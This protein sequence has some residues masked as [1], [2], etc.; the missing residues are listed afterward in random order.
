[1][2]AA[3]LLPL[4][5]QLTEGGTLAHTLRRLRPSAALLVCSE[6]LQRKF[7]RRALSVFLGGSPAARVHA[8]LLVRQVALAL[9][10]QGLGA[11]LKA[12]PQRRPLAAASLG[13]A[14]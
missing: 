13:R 10:E 7:L 4:A 6:R 3:F 5:G 8:F 1:M 12:R 14:P 9:P 11:A 2:P